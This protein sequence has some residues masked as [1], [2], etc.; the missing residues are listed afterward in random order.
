MVPYRLVYLRVY[1]SV[2]RVGPVCIAIIQF[3][4][5]GAA[6]VKCVNLP[7]LIMCNDDT[8]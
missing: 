2:V 3:F 7:M 5:Y 1:T 8:N 6:K 4:V